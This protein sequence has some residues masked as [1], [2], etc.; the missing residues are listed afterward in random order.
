M[1]WDWRD[2]LLVYTPLEG[3]YRCVIQDTTK[4]N[5][6]VYV[7]LYG[8]WYNVFHLNLWSCN[9]FKSPVPPQPSL[10]P[11]WLETLSFLLALSLS[12]VKWMYLLPF[13]G[14]VIE[15]HR[16]QLTLP[17]LR[18]LLL[19][20]YLQPQIFSTHLLLQPPLVP[21]AGECSPDLPQPL[22]LGSYIFPISAT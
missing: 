5:Q 11:M 19:V 4:K 22:I 1:S 21:A 20:T 9:N 13:Q 12:T 16:P 14:R 6:T 15:Q 7:A 10:L 3:T 8:M 2:Q 18:D 17:S